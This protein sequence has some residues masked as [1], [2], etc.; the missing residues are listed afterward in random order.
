MEKKIKTTAN[1]RL[2]QWGVMCKVEVLYFN[3]A[4]CCVDSLVFQTSPL[5]QAWER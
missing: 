2:A 4:L 1:T 3:Q 5:R